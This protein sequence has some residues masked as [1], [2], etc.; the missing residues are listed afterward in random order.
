MVDG[1]ELA[2]AHAGSAR[3]AEKLAASGAPG[4]TG[5]G[6]TFGDALQALKAGYRVAREGWKGKGMWLSLSGLSGGTRID[7]DKFWSPHNEA[8]ARENGGA[9]TVL[10]CITMK[11]TTGEILMGW[12]ASQTDMLAEDWMVVSA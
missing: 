5:M 4:P 6:L 10:P 8:F 1:T 11:T 9:A 7:A 2:R 3:A 12:L